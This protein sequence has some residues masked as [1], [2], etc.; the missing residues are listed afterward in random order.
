MIG[1]DV[2]ILDDAVGLLLLDELAQVVIEEGETEKVLLDL[3]LSVHGLAQLQTQR[4]VRHGEGL[5]LFLLKELAHLGIG[6]LLLRGTRH[7]AVH[8]DDDEQH[9]QIRKET[10]ALGLLSQ[11]GSLLA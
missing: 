4:G 7:E 3:R 2:V 9:Q 11:W 10:G 1:G 5:D 8:A 6:G